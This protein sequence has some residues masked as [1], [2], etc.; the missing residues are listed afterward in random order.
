MP[1]APG[2]YEVFLRMLAPLRTK[3]PVLR[4]RR[5]PAQRPG[6]SKQDYATPPEFIAAVLK[7]FRIP[8][9]DCDLAANETNAKAEVWIGEQ[10]DSLSVNWVSFAYSRGNL[11]LNPP[12]G[13]IDPWAKKCSE[14]TV[15]RSYPGAR[16]GRIFFLTPASVGANWFAEHVHGRALV[17][18]LQGRLS[19]DGKMP[20]PKDC[21]LSVFGE[22]PNFEVWD[23]RSQK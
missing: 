18:A 23:W 11:W 9:F 17:L 7:R 8:V 6:R 5:M 16:S 4:V 13:H 10:E 19:F 20:Y 21:C 2:A 1:F 12:F 15:S 22:K 3:D 14:Y